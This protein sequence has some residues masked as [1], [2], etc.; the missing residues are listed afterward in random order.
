MKIFFLCLLLA[1]ESFAQSSLPITKKIENAQS[2][3]GISISDEYSWLENTRSD[4]VASWVSSQNAF[5]QSHLDV[6]N[7]SVSVASKIK[8]FNFLSTNSLPSKTGKY[9]YSRYIK[10]KNRPASLFYRKNLADQSIEIFNTY[11]L[12]GNDGSFLM[13]YYPSKNSRLIACAISI[14]GSDRREIRFVNLD[15][16]N[17]M[18]DA[19]KQ[20]KFSSVSWN[21][22]K[23]IF[24]KK[25]ANLKEFEKDSTFQLYYHAIGKPQ[26]EDRL[27]FDASKTNNWFG[28][29]TKHNRLFVTETDARDGSRTYYSANLDNDAFDLKPFIE[30]DTTDMKMIGV[31]KDKFY[32]SSSDYDWGDVRY[33]TLENPS[34]RKVVIPQI[35]G[36]LLVDN[37]FTD[38]YI[39]CKYR[40]S[41]SY[42]LAV[43]DLNG[44]FIR[45][46]DAPYEMDF[47]FR[48]MNSQ[49]D[50]LYVTFHSSVISYR[51][52]K[53]DI[54][55]GTAHEFFNDYI[56][57]KSTLFPL[58]KFAIK[59][60]TYKSRDNKDIPITVIHDRDVILDGNNPTL[61]EAYG[62]YGVVTEFHYD[63]ALLTFLEK[64]GVYAYA[65]IR[66][67]GE[68][69]RQWHEAG[70]GK[71]KINTIHDFI[72][73]S[74]F[75]IENRYTSAGKL[76]ITG[77][78]HGGM[79]VASALVLE[80]ELYKVAIP[81]VGVMDMI[82]Y[83]LYTV[84]SKHQS[85]YGDPRKP[86]DFKRLM[87]FS[88]YHNVRD[89][90]NYPV[91]MIVTSEND[92]RVPPFHS[93]KFAAK[94]QSRA[95]QKNPIYL[96]SYT[97][98]GHYGTISNYTSSIQQ[99]ANFYDFLW[100]HLNN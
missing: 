30:K 73:A 100:Y 57:P 42:Y 49:D 16:R 10:D 67:G 58:D 33:F 94:L 48:F 83:D 3:F 86:D 87:A 96:L 26:S 78:S 52:F 34:E 22:D 44:Q 32:F 70:S 81:K 65:E 62:G 4:E 72:D 61:L 6:V 35:Y 21:E 39:F 47:N 71:N 25:N 84:G 90:V 23:G 45:K 89:E 41:G 17:L 18:D 5:T 91:T 7:K 56:R 38:K 76:G 15:N 54:K 93:Y 51:N 68:K 8:E 53:L 36:H 13:D 50:I 75:L 9:Y 55:N 20:I 77:G 60:L 80:P 82:N 43:Y 98:S 79:V 85:E 2:R 46:F 59:R 37:F 92:D 74:K 19:L 69:G 12:Y 1:A 40:K 11:K 14:A 88:P 64:G 29:Y 24:Y 99:K 28:A 27:I 97:K 95:A 66:G 63:T 31:T